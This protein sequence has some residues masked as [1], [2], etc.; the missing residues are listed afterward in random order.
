MS[1]YSDT[2][3]EEQ[4]AYEQWCKDQGLDHM[5]DYWL[6]YNEA[7]AELRAEAHWGDRA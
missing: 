4:E 1:T 3:G 7:V 2:W 5:L 6:E